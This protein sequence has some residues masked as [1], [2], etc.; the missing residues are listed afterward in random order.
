LQDIGDAAL[1]DLQARKS[2]RFRV[3]QTDSTRYGDHYT[4]GDKVTVRFGNNVELNRRIVGVSVTIDRS[5]EDVK[6]E[7]DDVP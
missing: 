7:M 3:I 6:L 2:F 1:Q 5:G 4:L